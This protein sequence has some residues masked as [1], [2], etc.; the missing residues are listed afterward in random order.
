MTVFENKLATFVTDFVIIPLGMTVHL[1][2]FRKI[3]AGTKKIIS[4]K[5]D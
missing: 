2:D 3:N 1:T 5:R 4:A